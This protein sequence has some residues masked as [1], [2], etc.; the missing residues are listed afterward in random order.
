[1]VNSQSTYLQNL[2][3]F[4]FRIVLDNFHNPDVSYAVD[5]LSTHVV[6]TILLALLFISK[7]CM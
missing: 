4:P 1:M 3:H 5:F 2:Y 6:A 7:V